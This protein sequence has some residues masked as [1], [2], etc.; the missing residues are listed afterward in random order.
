MRVI[1]DFG[2]NN[3]DDIPYYLMKADLV[4]AVEANPS[5]CDL[6]YKRFL[7]EINSDRLILENCVLTA[8]SVSSEVDFYIHKDDH[9]FSEFPITPLHLTVYYKKV[10]LSSKAVTGILQNYGTPH[11]IRI[12]IEH[13]DAQIL[14]A[15]FSNN[16]FPPYLSAES[17]SIEI[18]SILISE[19]RYNAFKLVDGHS[20]PNVYSDRRVVREK[21]QV[22]VRYS[23][24]YHSAGPYGN[25]IDGPW[26]NA[27]N[28]FRLLAFAGLGWIDI[29]VSNQ[30]K[31]DPFFGSSLLLHCCNYLKMDIKRRINNIFTR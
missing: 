23:F 22:E 19:G 8:D 9:G 29:H 30:E 20:V 12:D 14:R 10:V 16:I 1:Y 31:V 26:M 6:I 3:G 5:L 15:L 28:F 17:Q 13:Y 4:V 11:Y 24:P 27:N 2:S 7:P 21:D 25:D 18:F